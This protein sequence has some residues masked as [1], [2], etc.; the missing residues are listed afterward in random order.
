M[1]RLLAAATLFAFS[2]ITAMVSASGDPDAGTTGKV[3][4]P[5]EVLTQDKAI[6]RDVKFVAD[7]N[8]VYI[9]LFPEHKEKEIRVKLANEYFASY[10]EWHHGGYELVSPANQGK[11]PYGWTDFVNTSANYIEYWMDGEVILHLKRVK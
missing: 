7:E 9:Q 4:G 5:F 11:T 8:N 6:V 2:V 3:Y 1:N 10:R